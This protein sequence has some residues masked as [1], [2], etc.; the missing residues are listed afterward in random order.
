M[1]L[2]VLIAAIIGGWLAVSFVVAAI[3]GRAV[4]HADQD[5]ARH[6]ARISRHSA[7]RKSAVSEDSSW[8]QRTR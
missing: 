6:A 1:E 5:V 8:P 3:I 4:R 2:S 7:L